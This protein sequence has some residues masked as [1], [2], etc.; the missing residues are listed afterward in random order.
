MAVSA[1]VETAS[2]PEPLPGWWYQRVASTAA[3]KNPAGVPV[4]RVGLA[5]FFPWVRLTP[6]AAVRLATGNW[7]VVVVL[8]LQRLQQ[9]PQLDLTRGDGTARSRAVPFGNGA[10]ALR[11]EEL[12]ELDRGSGVVMVTLKARRH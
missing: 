5:Y 8:H 9:P 2:S 12:E 10:P 3:S 1:S 7:D 6:A 11:T 4:I